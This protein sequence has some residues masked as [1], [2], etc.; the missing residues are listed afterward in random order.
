MSGHCVW[1]WQWCLTLNPN[2]ELAGSP[3]PGLVVCCVPDN[4][5]PLFKVGIWPLAYQHYTANRH[6]KTHVSPPDKAKGKKRRGEKA[7]KK[8]WHTLMFYQQ[9]PWQPAG[10]RTLWRLVSQALRPSPGT[11]DT[12]FLED[13]DLKQHQFGKPVKNNNIYFFLLNVNI[14]WSWSTESIPLEGRE[15]WRLEIC[16]GLESKTKEGNETWKERH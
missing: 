16:F 10:P 13:H 9:Y 2:N 7:V 5:Y 11:W 4:V 6:K 8:D 15:L 3:V 1:H 12:L 14:C